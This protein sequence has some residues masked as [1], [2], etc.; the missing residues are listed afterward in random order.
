M[1]VYCPRV[2]NRRRLLAKVGIKVNVNPIDFNTLVTKLM[3]IDMYEAAAFAMTGGLDP[4]D[5]SMSCCDLSRQR[6]TMRRHSTTTRRDLIVWTP[7]GVDL[8]EIAAMHPV[9]RSFSCHSTRPI[10]FSNAR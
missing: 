1:F 2:R 8:S 10:F 6:S 3:G 5:G 9:G 4:N 7:L